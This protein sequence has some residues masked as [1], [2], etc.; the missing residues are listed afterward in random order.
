MI[1]N[2]PCFGGSNAINKAERIGERRKARH[3][4]KI[5]TAPEALR[6][7]QQHQRNHRYIETDIRAMP[8]PP[9]PPLR[10]VNNRNSGSSSLA[11][12]R[13]SSDGS[14]GSNS[15]ASRKRVRENNMANGAPTSEAIMR[16]DDDEYFDVDMDSQDAYDQLDFGSLD[17]PSDAARND[18]LFVPF[19]VHLGNKDF[20]DE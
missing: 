15:G 17:R 20:D 9:S 14:S 18:G 13:Q 4:T 8:A 12:P 6:C 11:A 19:Y 7:S 16:D 3:V 5:A 2:A 1:Q 10:R